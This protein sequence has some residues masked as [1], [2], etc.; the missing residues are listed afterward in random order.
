[1]QKLGIADVAAGLYKEYVADCESRET[2]DKGELC[3]AYKFL[4]IHCLRFQE[5]SDAYQYAQKC[6][7]YEEVILFFV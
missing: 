1:M 3:R 6:L 5:L 2:C 4:A 7:L